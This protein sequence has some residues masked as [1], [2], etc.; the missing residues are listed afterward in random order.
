MRNNLV[1]KNSYSIDHAIIQ[2][3]DE[4]SKSF[5]K[6]EYTLI[7]FLLFCGYASRTIVW[8]LYVFTIF[9]DPGYT[10][11]SIVHHALAL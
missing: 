3:I 1:F 4:I 6:N 7:E 9:A 11:S 5:G 8:A 2:L 10:R